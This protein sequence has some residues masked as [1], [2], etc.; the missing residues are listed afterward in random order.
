MSG[1]SLKNIGQLFSQGQ[2]LQPP[3]P[4][5]GGTAWNPWKTVSP[6]MGGRPGAQV[7]GT[8]DQDAF[9]RADS[10]YK[11]MKDLETQ[12]AKIFS[13][14]RSYGAKDPGHKAPGHQFAGKS[15]GEYAT[16][17]FPGLKTNLD[18]LDKDAYE[19]YD[20]F[21]KKRKNMFTYTGLV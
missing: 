2:S 12:K 14:L 7:T 15:S 4:F 3:D 21:E 5:E 19:T 9:N 10:H 8:F 16:Q 6:K 17:D 18:I 13:D 20:D 11:R 1:G